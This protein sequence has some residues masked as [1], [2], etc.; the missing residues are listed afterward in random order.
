MELLAH[1]TIGLLLTCAFTLT[2]GLLIYLNMSMYK[3]LRDELRRT[4]QD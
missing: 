1:I 2:L 4:S 3:I